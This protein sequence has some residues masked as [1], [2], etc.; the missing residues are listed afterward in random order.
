MGENSNRVRVWTLCSFLVF[1]LYCSLLY[2]ETLVTGNS[3]RSF[4]LSLLSGTVPTSVAI[5]IGLKFPHAVKL[6]MYIMIYAQLTFIAMGSYLKELDFYFF[7]TLLLVGCL[8]SMKD[9]KLLTK[10]VAIMTAINV[11]ALVFFFPNFDYLKD[12]FAARGYFRFIMQFTM[13]LFGSVF[14]LIQTYNVT[15]KEGLSDR[16]LSAFSALLKSTPNYM[17]ITDFDSRVRY[18][19]DYM[20]RFIKCPN[21]EQATGQHL[22]SLV[23]D[24]NLKDMFIDILASDDLYEKIVHVNIEGSERYFKILSSKLTDEAGGKFIE[25]SDTTLIVKSRQAAEEAQIK[26]EN[27]NR[28]KSVFLANMSHEI[29]TPMN[30][31]IGLSELASMDDDLSPKT[32]EYLGKIMDNSKW[33]L[34]II[35]DVLDISKIESGRMELETIPFELRD[36]FAHCQ[37]ATSSKALEKG[38]TLNF[39]AEPLADKKLLGDPTRL[40][41]VFINLI[42]NAIKFTN[43]GV[44]KLSATVKNISDDNCTMRFEVRDSGV[45]MTPEQTQR[46]FEPFMQA[47]SSTTRKHGGTGLG[48]AIAKNIIEVMGGALS[49]ESAP[50]IGSKFNFEI[51][52]KTTDITAENKFDMIFSDAKIEKPL[53]EGEVLI[54][55]D[56][57]LNQRVVFE[58]LSKVGL[59]AVIAENGKEAVDMVQKRIETGRKLFD[60]IFMD[61]QMPVMDGIEAA[62]KITE[63]NIGIPIVALTANIT[64]E[65]MNLYRKSGMNSYLSKPFMAQELWR[66]LL[67][68]LKPIGKEKEE[69]TQK[70]KK[71]AEKLQK[72][73]MADF[74]KD[75]QNSFD[76]FLQALKSGDIKLAHRISHTLKSNAALFGKF[77]LQ[78]AAA[79]VEL[80]LKTDKNSL[81]QEHLEILKTELNA[82]LKEFEPLLK[83]S[84]KPAE[85][86]KVIDKEKIR[87]MLDQL[88][89]LLRS[90]NPNS[91]D[92]VED[93]RSVPGS[94]KLMEQIE[95]FDFKPAVGTLAKLKEAI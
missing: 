45:G 82:V 51:V 27:A 62:S 17:A 76:E 83:E 59:Q 22:L 75:N 13:F 58:H 28:A 88:E 95:D 55:E 81:T 91:L 32:R 34:Q 66:C 12:Y 44:V 25:I 90:G 52:F 41:Q 50:G 84:L 15:Q 2:I 19:S 89:P 26:A 67:Q 18:L 79:N 85:S 86:D 1:A 94:E 60:L 54:C 80:I 87:A 63:L 31:V 4:I 92:F 30:S 61:I 69:N 71:A 24:K 68:Y 48:L 42:S 35:N 8:S 77:K 46:I 11:F 57:K 20:A 9:F 47:D 29:R 16:A 70:Q 21:K 43:V 40:C 72:E 5:I 14:L 39:Y 38:L 36:I 49:V 73:L 65:T 56:N 10:C 7:V 33:L 93:L 23:T 53:F 74:A 64:V 6:P 37:T 3:M 78:K